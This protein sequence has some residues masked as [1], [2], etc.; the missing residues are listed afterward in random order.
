MSCLPE[1]GGCERP[2]TDAFVNFLNRSEGTHYVHRACLDKDSRVAQPEA[3]YVD[4]QTN[5][6]LVIE[7]KSI[8]WPTDYPYRHSNDHFVSQVFSQ[9]LRDLK[10]NDLY[11]VRLPMLIRGKREEL[12]P[13]VLA[14]ADAIWAN[15]AKVESG[16]ALKQQ[17]SEDW[18]WG[19]RRL[20]ESEREDNSP[21]TGLL[22]TWVGRSMRLDEYL[23]PA[24]LP[25]DLAHAFRNIYSACTAKFAGY[26]NAQR[27]LILDPHGDL[28]H[29]PNDWWTELWSALPPA[30]EIEEIWSGVFDYIDDESQDWQFERLL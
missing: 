19:F 9:A 11:E 26:A 18:W 29:Q 8:S 23:D 7:R 25:E 13:F 6:E 17:V 1:S 16:S 5:R 24:K 4:A 15:W 2:F 3:L 30:L 22:F 14:A 28:R 21:P 27:V 10:L 12:R 20:P